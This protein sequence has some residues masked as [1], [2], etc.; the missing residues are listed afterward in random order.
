MLKDGY[1][2]DEEVPYQ[3]RDDETEHRCIEQRGT[4]ADSFR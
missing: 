2:G 3:E 1:E 4:E